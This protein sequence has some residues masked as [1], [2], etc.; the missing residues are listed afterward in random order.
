[1][2]KYFLW[3][4]L[5]LFMMACSSSSDE[6][7]NSLPSSVYN[8]DCGKTI[9]L[10]KD[11]SL[12]IDN[13]F[14]ASY[15]NGKIAG[16]HVG[17]T[18]AVF[19]GAQKIKINVR[20]TVTYLNY[21]VTDW[22]ASMNSVKKGH[23]GGSLEKESGESLFYMVKSGSKVKYM[24]G[25]SFEN[26]KLRGATLLVPYT[27]TDMLVS[28][29]M[30]KYFLILTGDNNIF[31]GGYDAYTMDESHTVVGVT[32]QTM[33]TSQYVARYAYLLAWIPGKKST[34]RS[35]GTYSAEVAVGK[36]CED[37]RELGMIE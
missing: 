29:L 8:V 10:E 4:F 14:I 34:T 18:E 25:Y 2:K 1:M 5:P 30:E 37:L 3:A 33:N 32:L 36:M 13:S 7:D 6:M 9:S 19:N 26:G 27:D 12:A 11:G 22:G 24:Y 21:P 23:E 20:G 31:S 16:K 17:M 15:S 28:W 35:V